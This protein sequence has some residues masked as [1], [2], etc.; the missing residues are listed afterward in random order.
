[1]RKFWIILIVVW[2][3]FALY[4]CVATPGARAQDAPEWTTGAGYARLCADKGVIDQ[5]IPERPVDIAAQDRLV[6][7]TLCVGVSLGLIDAFIG[8]HGHGYEATGYCTTDFN[9]AFFRG[10]QRMACDGYE[11][12]YLY[13]GGRNAFE[14]CDQNPMYSDLIRALVDRA[15]SNGHGVDQTAALLS[16]TLRGQPWGCK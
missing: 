8:A 11:M 9:T 6:R 12:A 15:N 4:E 10:V 7:Q 13:V 1:M 16:I 3:V 5:Y 2:V 14:K